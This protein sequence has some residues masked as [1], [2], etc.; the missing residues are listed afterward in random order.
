VRIGYVRTQRAADTGQFGF[1]ERD[2]EY[3]L[4]LARTWPD[5]IVQQ[6]A[7]QLPWGT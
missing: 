4:K 1:S 5:G 3:I 7:A 6:P 2:L